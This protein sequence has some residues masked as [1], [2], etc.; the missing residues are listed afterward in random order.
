MQLTFLL[1]TLFSLVLLAFA[2]PVPI[3]PHPGVTADHIR[4]LNP[5][6]AVAPQPATTGTQ[7]QAEPL[8]DAT[9]TVPASQPSPYKPI[10]AGFHAGPFGMISPGI[11][12]VIPP[13][14]KDNEAK[15][16][17]PFHEAMPFFHGTPRIGTVVNV[18]PHGEAPQGA[19]NA[20]SV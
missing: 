2:V 8:P 13:E 1:T 9:P 5:P 14:H 19:I 17:M 15:E 16:A 6:A 18:I 20:A 10:F 7:A 12:P 3:R 11:L 4:P